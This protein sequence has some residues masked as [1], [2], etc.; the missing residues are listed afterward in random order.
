MGIDNIE[1]LTEEVSLYFFVMR[2]AFLVAM[3]LLGLL[4]I[5]YVTAAWVP[6]EGSFHTKVFET[7]AQLHGSAQRNKRSVSNE[8]RDI[9]KQAM[10]YGKLRK[11]QELALLKDFNAIE[12][13]LPAPLAINLLS[14]IVLIAAVAP[15]FSIV[16]PSFGWDY[17]Q[18]PDS[19][20][21]SLLQLSFSAYDAFNTAHVKMDVIER[22]MKSI[23]GEL[24][25]S[26][27]TLLT[28]TDQE[29]EVILPGQLDELR[30]IARVSRQS[31]TETVEAFNVT[32]NILE[33]I[34]AGSK[35]RESKSGEQVKQL[36]LK[37][38][39]NKIK[40][41]L[42]EQ[43]RKE[44]QER[45]DEIKTKLIEYEKNYEE[46]IENI[47]DGWDLMGMK[48]CESLTNAFVTVIEV[49]TKES[50]EIS[51]TN[52]QTQQNND[53]PKTAAFPSCKLG[54]IGNFSD[55]IAA[56]VTDP[57][58][59]ADDY[60]ALFN[61]LH[62]T[63]ELLKE[64]IKNV[65]KE[66]PKFKLSLA[67]N[68]VDQT[69]FLRNELE[70]SKKQIENTG[71]NTVSYEIKG[72][73]VKLYQKI[74]DFIKDVLK[75]SE[76]IKT[77]DKEIRKLYDQGKELNSNGNCFNSWLKNLLQLP[78][79]SP[80]Q[81][82]NQNPNQQETITQKHLESAKAKVENWKV[83]MEEKEEAFQKTS[84]KL[85]SVSQN[86]TETI[87]ELAK[88][89]AEQ[90]SLK[91]ILEVLE[92]ALQKLNQLR[93]Y[94]L[95]ITEFFRK[96]ETII[97]SSVGRNIDKYV[98]NMERGKKVAS[99][100][101]KIYFKNQIY[102]YI[103]DINTQSYLV[104][105]MSSTYLNISDQYILP[106][107]RKLGLMLEADVEKSKELRAKIGTDTQAASRKLTILLENQK[108]EF[109]T[110]MNKRR[111]ELEN[112]YKPIF[113]KIPAERQ[114]VIEEEVKEAAATVP[115]AL[116]EM[117]TTVTVQNDLVLEPHLVDEF[118]DL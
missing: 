63:L 98:S 15:D 85:L 106:P 30:R 88:F 99:L 38:K 108:K 116:V 31:A 19:F 18:Y 33:E 40:K 52:R 93:V 4:T 25:F 68:V 35:A 28:G 54:N 111:D 27:I 42:W 86:I 6:A 7:G 72:P 17:L 48:V 8:I 100:R 89:N 82:F 102:T 20:K 34:I 59:L 76:N 92:D 11:D 110:K 96:I 21:S 83:M 81:P 77:S 14:Q 70:S 58:Q 117:R 115:A 16:T 1:T 37:I 112:M 71:A 97:D 55:N 114:R 87:I 113:D 57:K 22:N 53:K 105:R 101:N 29:V 107:V 13:L 91:K 44:L 75:N 109:L 50:L 3:L 12:K 43:Q 69:N 39:A 103:Q 64:Y 49:F 94:W 104:G 78:P 56:P 46:A 10:T 61:N 23:P 32:K 41:E 84:D 62:K 24:R 45:K 65:F 26:L 51:N 79:I 9:D 90:E 36:D 60:M 73:A 118:M 5:S 67:T 2:D 66:P 95:E 80:Q 74:F 47:P